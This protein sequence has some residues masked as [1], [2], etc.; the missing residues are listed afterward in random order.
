[1]WASSWVKA[2]TRIS[3]CRAPEASRR[4]TSRTRP[5]GAAGR[6][7]CAGRPCRPGRGRGSSSASRP[8]DARYPRLKDEHVVAVLVP[9]ARFHPEP[10]IEQLRGVD[11]LVAGGARSG[12]AC[13]LSKLRIDRPALVV[14][15]DLSPGP[16]P[17]SGRGPSRGRAGGGR[18]ARPPR[19]GRRCASSS[20]WSQR[21]CRRCA[22]AGRSW[23]RRASRSPRSWSA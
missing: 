23:H 1:M 15:E 11:L 5:S 4:K 6:D 14:P 19:A 13:R 18:G 17:G 16:P 3:P 12:G 2:W 9:V 7:S 8:P 20:F 22:A 10:R 21:P